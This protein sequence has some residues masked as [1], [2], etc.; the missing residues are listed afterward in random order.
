LGEWDKYVLGQDDVINVH[1]DDYHA[2]LTIDEIY[3]DV[4]W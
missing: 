4:R 2:S 1:C 3:E